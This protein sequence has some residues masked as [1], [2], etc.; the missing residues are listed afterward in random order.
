MVMVL[1]DQVAVTPDGSPVAVPIPVA[2]V[3]VWVMFVNGVFTQS[4]GAEDPAVVVFVHAATAPLNVKLLIENC[5]PDPLAPHT[6]SLN[7]IFVRM[8]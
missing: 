2:P 7:V 1:A 3:V 8:F 5:V 4:V 6:Y